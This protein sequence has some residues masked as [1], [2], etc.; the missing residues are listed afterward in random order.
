MALP[1][2]DAQVIASG[3]N[4]VF[5]SLPSEMAMRRASMVQAVARQMSADDID[6]LHRLIPA[7]LQQIPAVRRPGTAPAPAEPEKPAKSRRF[8]NRRS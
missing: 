8:W 3:Y 5:D 7:L 6:M 2:R 4:R 1:E